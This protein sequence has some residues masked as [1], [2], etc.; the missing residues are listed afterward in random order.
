MSIR[1]IENQ[2]FCPKKINFDFNGLY[3]WTNKSFV[4]LKDITSLGGAYL[5]SIFRNTLVFKIS[6]LD[7]SKLLS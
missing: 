7:S 5:D 2:F 3:L 1:K 6:I 4:T